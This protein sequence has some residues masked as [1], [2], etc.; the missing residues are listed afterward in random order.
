MKSD[1]IITLEITEEGGKKSEYTVLA[2]FTIRNREYIALVTT[3]NPNAIELYR[4]TGDIEG[5]FKLDIIFSDMELSEAKVEFDKMREEDQAAQEELPVVTLTDGM[6]REYL[7]DIVKVF[8]FNGHDYIA[9]M[10]QGQTADSPTI[11]LFRY[12][13]NGEEMTVE[14]IPQEAFDAVTHHFLDIAEAEGS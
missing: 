14:M 5:D 8:D 12:I 6:G 1:D 2:T 11:E 10:P 7:C 4:L 3:E 13:V 9:L